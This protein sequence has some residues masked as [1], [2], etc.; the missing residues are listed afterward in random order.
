M[1]NV[2]F[3]SERSKNSS[4]NSDQ[5]LRKPTFLVSLNMLLQNSHQREATS[6]IDRYIEGY[7]DKIADNQVT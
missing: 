3:L 4:K 7:I 6:S 5:L 1:K 2:K